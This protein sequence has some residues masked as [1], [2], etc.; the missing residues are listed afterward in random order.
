MGINCGETDSL[1]EQGLF[2]WG[3]LSVEFIDVHKL[4]WRKKI[5][6]NEINYF[7]IVYN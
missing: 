5:T 7:S 6:S 3:C 1:F 4:G 2:S